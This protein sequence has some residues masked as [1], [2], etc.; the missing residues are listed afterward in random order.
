MPSRPTYS[1]PSSASNTPQAPPMHA[2]ASLPQ[3][4]PMY[5]ASHPGYYHREDPYPYPPPPPHHMSGPPAQRIYY[6]T[7]PPP[8]PAHY[9]A[10]D[11]WHAEH[12]RHRDSPPRQP[13]T[14]R[15]DGPEEAS[16]KG[17]EHVKRRRGRPK[18]V[19]VPVEMQHVNRGE[20]PSVMA[21][22]SP[23][24]SS[25]SDRDPPPPVQQWSGQAMGRGQAPAPQFLQSSR[26][27]D[28]IHDEPEQ[29]V[30][31][32]E[33][34][35][36]R[37]PKRA[38]GSEERSSGMGG[39]AELEAGMALAGLKRRESAPTAVSKKTSSLVKAEPG[40]EKPIV[41]KAEKPS[42]AKSCAECRR[43]KAKCD[44]VFPCSNCRRRGCAV[45]CPDG[46]LSCMQGKRLVLASTEQLHE[47]I[48]QLE[49]AL[50]QTHRSAVGGTSYHPLLAPQF[51][52]GGFA[53]VEQPPI[54]VD[55]K[56]P[57]FSPDSSQ[58]GLGHG[59]P[60][61]ASSS[62]E[63][64]TLTTPL[65]G[66]EKRSNRSSRMAVESLLT[67]DSAV[68]EGKREDE[69]AGEN[70][71]PAMI[72]G[73]VGKP[74]SAEDL[75]QRHSVFARLKKIITILPPRNVNKQRA[76][77]FFETS[78]WYQTVLHRNEYDTVYEP[79]VYAPTAANPLSPHKLAVVLMVLTFETYL[80]ISADENDPKLADYWDGAQRCFDTRFGWAASVA[81][82]QALALATLFVGF[83]WRGTR[84]SNFYWLRQMTSAALQLGLHRDAHSSF[85]DEEKEF[86]RR[87]FHE[88]YVIDSLICLNHGQRASIPVEFIET[89]YPTL[90]SPLA[91]TKYDFIRKVKSQVID[92]GSLPDSAPASW[93]KVK[94]V[95]E[96]LMEY[97]VDRLP[98]VH[99]PLLRGEQPPDPVEGFTHADAVALQTTT[100][101]MC[102]YKAMLYLFRPSLRRLIARIRSSPASSI[103]FQQSDIDTVK[104]TLRACNSI[105][106]TS[107][108]L[109][110]KHPKLMAKSWM[111]WVQT[112]SA[113]VSMTA[114][115][116]WCG[117]Y[118]EQGFLEDVSNKL[119]EA[120]NMIGENGSPRSQGVLSLLPTLKSLLAGR[121]PQLLGKDATDAR[122]S[123]EGEDMLFALLGGHVDAGSSHVQPPPAQPQPQPQSQTQQPLQ[124]QKS[125]AQ[126]SSQQQSQQPSSGQ[127]S[128]QQLHPQQT[129]PSH[130]AHQMPTQE[131]L[132]TQTHMP[133][134]IMGAHASS[135]VQVF[136]QP[137]NVNGT[138]EAFASA[139]A[140]AFC[141]PQ[142]QPQ[143]QGQM[144]MSTSWMVPNLPITDATCGPVILPLA[145]PNPT[146]I[147]YDNFIPTSSSN[148]LGMDGMV[149]MDGMGNGGDPFGGPLIDNPPE[150]WERLQALYE[151]QAPVFWNGGMDGGMTVGD[152]GG[153]VPNMY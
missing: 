19:P 88:I 11:E 48:S 45:V 89:A 112:F 70:A 8:P 150:L 67:E 108:Y 92:I 132:V 116:I 100:T 111:V 28:F 84:A 64:F 127:L 137:L 66:P 73:T 68:P 71:A 101:S 9:H 53:S 26:S 75:E 33:R 104:M 54:T 40:E 120:C 52:D 145:P 141:Q 17:G 146:A 95:E 136:S 153:Y 60:K 44:R 55:S 140:S 115:G 36:N 10:R 130:D 109:A 102:H 83:G 79:A 91:Y 37:P 25:G 149:M 97:D 87:V 147:P 80:D 29:I 76:D 27:G 113:A 38:R 22:L 15:R 117:P 5:G 74:D 56:P 110:R 114:L 39:D 151:P 82:V 57:S 148:N 6:N 125:S 135:P 77:H 18:K 103:T 35:A 123:L 106:L 94:E 78:L 128:T 16:P 21:P 98:V 126:T 34:Q 119:T 142:P 81:G 86:R 4:Y 72:I 133:S 62:A 46:D 90:S 20:Y 138:A 93:A 99:C 50:A 13:I 47:R 65:L 24:R 41:K 143:P 31:I 32:N 1:A 59:S 30:S 124:K 2:A 139:S 134:Q 23:G 3:P 7:A 144:P 105:I 49:Q 43:L 12:A 152:F 42:N 129:T 51:L 121:Y 107:Y 58:N 131:Q 69:W 61:N 85:P 122:V 96:Q 63:S 14:A 118:M